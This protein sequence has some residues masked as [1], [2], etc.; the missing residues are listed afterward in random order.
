MALSLNKIISILSDR[1]GQPFNVNLQNELKDIIGYKRADYTRQFLDNNPFERK[2]F[3]QSFIVEVEETDTLDCD[4]DLECP[5]FISCELPQ[6]IR[7]KSTIWDYVGTA[8]YSHSFGYLEPE[9]IKFHQASK[10]T[11]EKP[12][13]FWQDNRIVITNIEK[14]KHI[15]VR[16]ILSDPTS[17]EKCAC[18]LDPDVQVCFDPDAPYPIAEDILNAV[19]RDI[20]NVELRNMFP[21]PA[22]V[23]VDK[24]EDAAVPGGE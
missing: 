15:G 20:L 12:K 7:S 22:V 18:S 23:N 3:L 24:V 16:G 6:P 5:W 8:D 9:Y 17:F 4:V 2:E 21:Q 1:V 11:A 13:W 10:Y 19:M 14:I